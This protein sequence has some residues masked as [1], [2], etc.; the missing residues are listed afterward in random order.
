M[1]KNGI[2]NN[3][4]EYKVTVRPTGNVLHVETPGEN[5]MR[6]ELSRFGVSA[7]G[8]KIPLLEDL[9][10]MDIC[11]A[12]KIIQPS[13]V[14]AHIR[15]HSKN[16]SVCVYMQKRNTGVVFFCVPTLRKRA[17]SNI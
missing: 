10:M 6:S 1:Q 9:R 17:Y 12:F 14:F 4:F 16:S 15:R 13:G 5:S 3:T 8:I 2:I 7:Y 11:V